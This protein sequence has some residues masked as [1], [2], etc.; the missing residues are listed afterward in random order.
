MKNENCLQVSEHLCVE[1]GQQDPLLVPLRL[2]FP[3]HCCRHLGKV[4]LTACAKVLQGHG[5]GWGQ[6]GRE[7]CL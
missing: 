3:A 5:V 6:A 4:G 7:N 2:H 1:G